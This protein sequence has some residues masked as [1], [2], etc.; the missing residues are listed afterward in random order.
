L[1]SR[2]TNLGQIAIE[3]HHFIQILPIICDADNIRYDVRNGKEVLIFEKELEG[4]YFV[5]K[6]LRRVL[7]V[8]ETFEVSETLTY[9]IY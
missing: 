6:E 9:L 5:L 2:A 7:N 8:S 3:K 4:Y 1:V